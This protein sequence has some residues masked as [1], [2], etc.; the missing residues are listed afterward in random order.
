MGVFTPPQFRVMA[1]ALSGQSPP[2]RVA[3]GC[4]RGGSSD[5]VSIAVLSPRALL[6]APKR[7][8]EFTFYTRF[9]GG[10]SGHTSTLV[11]TLVK[12]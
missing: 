2:S 3:R 7:R 10:F 1:G 8:P 11:D 5:C 6:L 12:N 9:R 4:A